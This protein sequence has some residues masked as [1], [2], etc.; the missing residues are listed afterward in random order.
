MIAKP[1]TGPELS[2]SAH[3][4]TVFGSAP[5]AIS[6]VLCGFS[7]ALTEVAVLVL[8]D[9]C[10]VNFSGNVNTVPSSARK[11]ARMAMGT[12][13]AL[14]SVIAV[15]HQPPAAT[16]ERVPNRISASTAMTV[17][18]NV[19][20]AVAEALS[21]TVTVN[22]DVP[23][24]DGVPVIEPLVESVKSENSAPDE[25][26]H[27][28]GGFPPVATKDCEYGRPMAAGRSGDGV[29]VNMPLLI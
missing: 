29:I 23:V 12:D 28:Y 10:C 15:S 27:A 21:L 25:I 1:V 3:P 16:W 11:I 13:E 8:L 18:L 5:V 9:P 7:K 22:S 17:M 2:T 14:M 19:W 20:V 4:I 6:T 24:A 26:D